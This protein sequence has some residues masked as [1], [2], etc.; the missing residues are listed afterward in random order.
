MDWSKGVELLTTLNFLLPAGDA[1]ATEAA[2]GSDID[3]SEHDDAAA[4][5]TTDEEEGS[6]D[7]ST[8][9]HIDRQGEADVAAQRRA[10][11]RAADGITGPR[12]SDIE[13]FDAVCLT[14][15][16][17]LVSPSS[18]C[19]AHAHPLPVCCRVLFFLAPLFVQ[20]TCVLSGTY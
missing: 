9:E 13:L 14:Q 6:D 18:S 12:A 10:A 7:S 16:N 19:A 15:T 20:M 3:E 2:Y 1:T 11:A 4:R 5:K 8:I 17:D